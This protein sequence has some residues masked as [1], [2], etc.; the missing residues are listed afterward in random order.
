MD[1]GAKDQGM[2]GVADDTGKGKVVRR[3]SGA[4]DDTKD[5]DEEETSVAV[6]VGVGCGAAVAVAGVAAGAVFAVKSLA[7]QQAATADIEELL[8]NGDALPD[9][10]DVNMVSV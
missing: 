4:A 6:W 8:A 9:V 10:Q 3:Q 5:E 1:M 2:G 7:A